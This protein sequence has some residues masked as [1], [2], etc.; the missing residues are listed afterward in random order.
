MGG[1]AND[2]ERLSQDP[3]VK[4]VKS[5]ALLRAARARKCQECKQ[6]SSRFVGSITR[7]RCPRSSCGMSVI[8]PSACVLYGWEK[9]QS[10]R[11]EPRREPP[12]G[13][14][15][16]SRT[17]IPARAGFRDYGAVVWQGP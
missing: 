2:A 13:E 16:L 15:A 4:K 8:R 10:R 3:T 5:R 12:H 6:F 1:Y 14:K 11:E 9:R 7:R 17:C